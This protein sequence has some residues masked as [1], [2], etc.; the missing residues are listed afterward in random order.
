[1]QWSLI[2]LIISIFILV[3]Q[4]VYTLNWHILLLEEAG[5]K[6]VIHS[7]NKLVGLVASSQVKFLAN[8]IT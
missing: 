7:F 1:M 5:S 8:L 6:M 4:F 2:T 3:L